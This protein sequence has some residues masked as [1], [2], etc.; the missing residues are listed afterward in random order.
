MAFVLASCMVVCIIRRCGSSECDS[1]ADDDIADGADDDVA[2]VAQ[3][4]FGAD[5]A[6]DA[7]DIAFI[8]VVCTIPICGTSDCDSDADDDTADGADHDAADDAADD[9]IAD[10]ACADV[11][12]DAYGADVDIDVDNDADN[13]A[14]IMI[15]CMIPRWGTS[16]YLINPW[17]WSSSSLST[18]LEILILLALPHL[19]IYFMVGTGKRNSHQ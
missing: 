3:E 10:G 11:A 1:D 13:S 7:D 6:D 17:R 19:I 15:V 14:S 5:V 2:D 4:A 12:Q 18:I 9:D 8:M 16:L